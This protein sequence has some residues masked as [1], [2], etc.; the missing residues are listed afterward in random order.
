MEQ[1]KLTQ[2]VRDNVGEVMLDLRDGDRFVQH[3]DPLIRVNPAWL[4]GHGLDD[5][6][7]PDGRLVLDTAGEYQYA[8]RAE[9]PDG[10]HVFERIRTTPGSS[11]TGG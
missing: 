9:L 10:F 8:H 5:V 2:W 11:P 1:A 3:A 4:R 7:Q 6:V